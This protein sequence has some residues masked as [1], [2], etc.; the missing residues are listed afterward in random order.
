MPSVKACVVFCNLD[1][2]TYSFVKFT[3]Q[4]YSLHKKTNLVLNVTYYSTINLDIPMSRFVV[5]EYV[6][7]SIRL[8][9]YTT[10]G[11]RLLKWENLRPLVLV[12]TR[13]SIGTL[14]I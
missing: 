12:L 5:L 11:V 2:K 10:E 6:T 3:L 4:S 8:V 14:T 13:D 9:F 1:H 7:S